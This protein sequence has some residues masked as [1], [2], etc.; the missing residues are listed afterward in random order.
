M[1]LN[2]SSDFSYSQTKVSTKYSE[3][4]IFTSTKDGRFR[5]AIKVTGISLCVILVSLG[6]GTNS[7]HLCEVLFVRAYKVTNL[8]KVIREDA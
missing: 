3:P 8:S 2:L 7:I 5:T 1:L 4:F 6:F